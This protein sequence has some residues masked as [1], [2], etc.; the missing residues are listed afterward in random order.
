MGKKKAGEWE[1]GR[2]CRDENTHFPFSKQSEKEPV[3]MSPVSIFDEDTDNHTPSLF[4]QIS[5]V[6]LLSFGHL[7]YRQW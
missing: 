3:E 1:G 5:A 7:Q 2:A 6:H 4:S